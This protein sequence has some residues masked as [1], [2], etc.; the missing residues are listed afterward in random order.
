MTKYMQT[1]YKMLDSKLVEMHF[2]FV[3]DSSIVNIK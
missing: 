3:I 1:R 2:F